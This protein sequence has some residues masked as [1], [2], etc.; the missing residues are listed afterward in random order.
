MLPRAAHNRLSIW[1][2]NVP[3][4]KASGEKNKAEGWKEG[5]REG[6]KERQRDG[7]LI[8]Y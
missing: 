6:Q 7:L 5:E 4:N 8:Y 3:E 2:E 1:K